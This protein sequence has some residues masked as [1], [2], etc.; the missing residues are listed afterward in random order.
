MW[1]PVFMISGYFITV[2]GL[3]ML[4]PAGV[5]VYYTNANW[6]YFITSSIIALFVGLS[7]FLANN[8]KIKNISLKQGYLLTCCSWFSVAFLAAVPFMLWGTPVA[9]AVFEAFSGISTTGATIYK[10]VESLPRAILLWRAILHGLG[11]I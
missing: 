2:L 1:Q 7:L 10:D 4:I 9:D 5:D 3:A 11:G 6:S 8:S